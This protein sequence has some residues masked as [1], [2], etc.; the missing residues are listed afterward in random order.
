MEEL[1]KIVNKLQD[2]RGIQQ[3]I[4]ICGINH[5]SSV[6]VR[7]AIV[8]FKKDN[9][10]VVEVDFIIE[11]GGGS[12]DDA[13]RIIRSLRNNFEKVNIVVP[14]WVKS[15]ATLLSLGGSEIIMD[16]FG[17]FGPLDSQL[18]DDT[19]PDPALKSA[20]ID[21]YS[22]S[23]IEERSQEYYRKLITE[24]VEYDKKSRLD[25]D[26][27][28]KQVLEYLSQFY[29]P[30]LD[31]VDT[32]ELGVKARALAVGE[33]YADRIL[34][35]YNADNIRDDLRRL[36]VD[37]LVHECP[38]HGYIV[39]YHL[40]KIFMKNV[41]QSREI[42]EEYCEAL[43]E[44]S[45]LFLKKQPPEFIGFFTADLLQKTDARAKKKTQNTEI[46]SITPKTNGKAAAQV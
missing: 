45:T 8:K 16:E 12:P 43:C 30:L 27:M 7:D 17:E 1:A 11:S 39:D 6:S 34:L 46:K 28:S 10:E 26:E 36:F 9:P 37:Y 13:Y 14:Y 21:E 3:F 35:Q 25:K 18:L 23:T 44:L 22:I 29:R 42:S 31:K 5:S 20:L 19:K 2:L 40:M 33:K 32:Y 15:A 38:H 4:F 24:L 41:R